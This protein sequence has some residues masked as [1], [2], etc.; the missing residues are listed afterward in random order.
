[1]SSIQL[2]GLEGIPE[3]KPGDQLASYIVAATRQSGVTIA[4]GDVLVVA[5]KII[6][7]AEGRLV[8]LSDTEP[9]AFA[10][11]LA[12]ACQRDPR[13]IELVLRESRRIV[14]MSDRVIITET[15]HGLICANAGIDHSNVAGEAV[16]SLLPTDPDLSAR[17]LRA[18][19]KQLLDTDVAIVITDTFGRPWREGL[20]NV[21]IGLAGINPLSDL[22]NQRDNHGKLLRATVLA[23]ADELAS[24]AGLIMRKTIGVP[25]VLVT[26][27]GY[28]AGEHRASELLRAKEHDL[29]R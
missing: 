19:L 16:V 22:R 11:T 23:T 6:S 29:F 8:H 28:E 10:K 5:Q 18:E 21:A 1:M 9:S 24:A 14:R 13:F 15:H 17:R 27:C 3:V 26:G 2:I 20:T 25:V 4:Q 12:A 7:K